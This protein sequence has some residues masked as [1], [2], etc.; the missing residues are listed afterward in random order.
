MNNTTLSPI[1]KDDLKYTKTP[2]PSEY[3]YEYTC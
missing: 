3:N 2:N 1:S